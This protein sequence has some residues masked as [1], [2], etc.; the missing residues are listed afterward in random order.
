MNER[1][2]YPGQSGR[3]GGFTE[4]PDAGHPLYKMGDASEAKFISKLRTKRHENEMMKSRNLKDLDKKIVKL[5]YLEKKKLYS[6]DKFGLKAQLEKIDEDDIEI[7]KKKLEKEQKNAQNESRFKVG[8]TRRRNMRTDRLMK[9]IGGQ[10]LTDEAIQTD[11]DEE[12]LSHHRE[13][14]SNLLKSEEDFHQPIML[15]AP[16]SGA[17]ETVIKEVQKVIV[18]CDKISIIESGIGPITETDL[19]NAEETGAFIFSF[20]V[21]ISEGVRQTAREAKII[22]RSFKLIFNMTDTIKILVNDLKFAGTNTDKMEEAANASVD[23][24]FTIKQKGAPSIIIA[25]LSVKSGQISR[26]LS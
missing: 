13:L 16:S 12:E 1:K 15:K 26:E 6:G 4:L 19:L 5:D 9:M 8:K 17:L 25:G 23:Q 10:D 3:I 2:L 22:G 14:F 21:P 20:D 24:I 18:N 7:L 11:K